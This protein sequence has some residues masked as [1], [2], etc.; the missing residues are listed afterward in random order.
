M[1]FPT[2]L[3]ICITTSPLANIVFVLKSKVYQG[4]LDREH[5]IITGEGQV[6]EF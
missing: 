6:P 1:I 3:S 4:C 2:F 5:F